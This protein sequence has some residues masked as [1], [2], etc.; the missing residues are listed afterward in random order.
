[1]QTV[2]LNTW[3]FDHFSKPGPDKWTTSSLLKMMSRNTKTEFRILGPEE[4]W[5]GNRETWT[6]DY[7]KQIDS[8]LS[9]N[10]NTLD[11]LVNSDDYHDEPLS[12]QVKVHC[13]P[14]F[15]VSQAYYEYTRPD[16]E[17][18]HAHN[19]RVLDQQVTVPFINMNN[20]AWK[21][22]CYMVDELARLGILDCGDVSWNRLTDS[23]L[24]Q[25]W[26]ERIINIDDFY[27]QAHRD[28]WRCPYVYGRSFIDLVSET[29][30]GMKF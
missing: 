26:T 5:L 18:R 11:I 8:Y 29:S 13:W 15:W 17:E 12:P 2:I 4:Y 30:V 25:H 6:A 23:Y 7:W 22:R 3:D 9:K 1:M 19:K 27:T 14:T 21:H 20:G 10:K 28:F 16:R 24:W